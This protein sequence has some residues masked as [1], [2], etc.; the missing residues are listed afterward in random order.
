MHGE[1][2]VTCDVHVVVA[3][4]ACVLPITFCNCVWEGGYHVD[5]LRIDGHR[6]GQKMLLLWLTSGW[7]TT[8]VDSVLSQRI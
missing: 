5:I 4:A 8:H 6:L 2:R 7:E 1:W 3:A